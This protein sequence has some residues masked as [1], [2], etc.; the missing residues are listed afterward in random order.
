[1]KNADH[2]VE[3]AAPYQNQNM[4]MYKKYKTENR[5]MKS[6][7]HWVEVEAPNQN[8]DMAR[9]KYKTDNNDM[10]NTNHW[11]EV[12]TP[13]QYQDMAMCKK[14][15]TEMEKWKVQII[16]LG[17]PHLTRIFNCEQTP[18]FTPIKM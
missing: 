15:I 5:Q 3:V 2:W 6:T 16:E 1:M 4:A 12:A 8:K 11:V 10:K 13:D 7:N 14:Y 9:Q 17:W 18:N